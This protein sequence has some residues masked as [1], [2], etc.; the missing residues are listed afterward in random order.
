MK[1]FSPLLGQCLFGKKEPSNGVDKN[2]VTVIR[3]NSCGKEEMVG[4]PAQNISKVI[5]LYL[6][7]PNFSLELEVTGKRVSRG[8]GYG[9]KIPARFCFYGPEKSTQW[10]ETRL[11]KNEGQLKE[12]VNYWVK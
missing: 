4:H 8:G 11:T 12:S 7:L 6:S 10:L 1:V 3:L 2:S 9:L 5:S